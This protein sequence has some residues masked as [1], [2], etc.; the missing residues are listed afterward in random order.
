MVRYGMVRYGMVGGEVL[1]GR[2]RSDECV[3]RLGGD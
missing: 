2:G 1:G 3:Y